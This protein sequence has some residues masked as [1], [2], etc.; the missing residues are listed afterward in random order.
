MQELEEKI[1]ESK[2]NFNLSITEERE[3][4]ITNGLSG[5]YA[6][7]IKAMIQK[8]QLIDSD[9]NFSDENFI[10]KLMRLLK[11]PIQ[12]TLPKYCTKKGRNYSFT[13]RVN[14]KKVYIKGSY[15]LQKA[16]FNYYKFCKLH[17][18]IP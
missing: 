17:N 18:L 11:L 2:I 14:S 10:N 1:Y 12:E 7:E 13:R 9:N 5:K 15:N 3:L 4:E 6:F 16:L 8:L